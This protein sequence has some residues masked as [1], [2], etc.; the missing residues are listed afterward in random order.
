MVK[1]EEKVSTVNAGSGQ[2]RCVSEKENYPTA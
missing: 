2:K 1:I